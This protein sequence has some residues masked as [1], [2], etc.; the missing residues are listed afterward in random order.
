MREGC[1]EWI[2]GWRSR[3]VRG[4]RV[5]R[6]EEREGWGSVGWGVGMLGGVAGG[7]GEG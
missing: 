7:G 2:G 5:C 4:R 6:R 3:L 1:V